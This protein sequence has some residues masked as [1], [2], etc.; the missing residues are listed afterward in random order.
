MSGNRRI[1]RRERF[2]LLAAGIAL[3]WLAVATGWP[4]GSVAVIHAQQMTNGYADPGACQRCHGD[5]AASYGKTG[6]GQ[7]FHRAGTASRIEDF[8]IHNTIYNQASDRYYRMVARDGA[9]F[10]QRFQIGFG[11]K[12]T[13]R[14]EM[15]IDYIVG[16]GNHAHTYLHR[17]SEGKLIELPVSWYSELGGYWEMSPGYDDAHQQDFRRAIPYECMACHNGYPHPD[18]AANPNPDK[19]I[20][21]ADLPEGIDCQ[22]CHGP[23]QAHIDAVQGGKGYEAIRSAIV[24]PARLS[25]D[26]QMEVCMQCHLETTSW[27]LPHA[28]RR[29]DKTAFSYRP[30][31]PLEDYQLAFDQKPGTGY[32]DKFQV[33][34]QAYRLRK[35]ACFQNS[36]MT[37]ITC[38]DPHK[39]L[40]GD[41]ATKHYIAVCSS[42]HRNIHARG[43][44]GYDKRAA[45]TVTDPPNC[46]T[47][48]MWKRR[49]E[50]AV[51]VVMTDHDIQRYRPKE[52]P[53]TPSKQ[54]AGYY[55][56]EVVPY[57]PESFDRVPDGELYLGI[58]QTE[59]DANLQAGANR[60]QH[61]IA[62]L[63]P[64]DAEIYFAMG[65]AD[66]KLGRNAEAIHWYQE[67]LRR[68]PQDQKILRALGATLDAMGNLQGAAEAGE[69]AVATAHPDTLAL[70][71]L[72]SVYLKLGR[73]D[74]AKRVL[75]EALSI[76]AN[77]PNAAVL[78]GMALMREGDTAGAELQYRSA[79]NIEPDLAEPY[80]NLA[81]IL[82]R[83]GDYQ[84]AVYEFNA[85]VKVDPA[86]ASIRLNYSI[87]LAYTGVLDKAAVEAREA[88]RLAPKSAPVHANLGNILTKSGDQSGAEHEYRTALALDIENGEANLGLA[89]LLVQQGKMKDAQKYY[90]VAA[91]S[92]NAQVRSAALAALKQ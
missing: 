73:I 31:E 2:L 63:K 29:F 17:T 72:G 21:G 42:C 61:A 76:D 37:C 83:R 82:A 92:Q 90:S 12:E 64:A 65:A 39:Q 7:S 1:G 48:H 71:D 18:P 91:K 70:T 89:N 13:N 20:F 8:Q 41:E 68:R 45:G 67:A 56:G 85:A 6:M 88:V 19:N 35:S 80:N 11:G 27:P 59:D 25:R 5:I 30:G 62:A 57:Y 16:S 36:Q 43:V 23:G 38:H 51:H 77:I 75:R 53:L 14:E 58:A 47:C 79:I 3:A 32:D 4:H 10:E 60:L 26:R 81:G 28:L 66:S 52:D 54:I 24:N 40:S 22:R 74:D 50:D 46:L 86:N 69:K 34:S 78:L 55:R 33:V 84:E 44:P 49:T 15:R 87:V 9:L